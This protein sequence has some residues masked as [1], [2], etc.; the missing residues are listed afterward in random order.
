MLAPA[1]LVLAL[2]VLPQRP[3]E[4]TS[5]EI[6][7]LVVRD[8]TRH[9]VVERASNDATRV[10]LTW[11]DGRTA[12]ARVGPYALVGPAASTPAF[13]AARLAPLG[14][15]PVT[16]LS[17]RLGIVRV[18]S[19]TPGEDG[20]SIAARLAAMPDLDVL[21]D[22]AFARRRAAIDIP[23]DDPR[24]GGQWYLD[25][26]DIHAAWAIETGDP[27]V[28]V[29][30]VDD[31]CDL[32]HP[33]LAA[34]IEPGYDLVDGDDDPSFAPDLPGNEHGTA[35]AGLVAAIGDNGVGI[36]G[37][38][39]ECH[40]RCVRLLPGG[41]GGEVPIG[42]DIA[43]YDRQLEWDVAVSSNSWGF[44]ERFPVPVL[45]GR[46]ITTLATQGRGGL[47]AIVLFAI[48]NDAREV[49]DDELYGLEGVV[50][51]G[52]I[53]AFDEAAQ[54]S[55]RGRAL[56]LVAPAG[57][58]TTDI[59]GRD[60]ADPGDYT[61]LFGGTSS[62]CPVAAGVA[63]LLVAA[64]PDMRA[65]AIVG[66]LIASARPAPFAEPDEHGHDLLYGYGIIAPAAALALVVPPVVEPEPIAEEVAPEPG[67]EPIA[68]ASPEP[69][70]D[71]AEVVEPSPPR[72]DDGCAGGGA[73]TLLFTLAFG[74][75]ASRSRRRAT[76]AR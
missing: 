18:R 48:G 65:E 23:P 35:C 54:F 14:L 52:A 70:E 49:Q 55:N 12:V 66:A 43:A 21:P 76:R 17:E 72:R 27:S 25:T 32:A 28:V 50:T 26:I 4:L 56:D 58:L 30:V 46:A 47:G 45:L 15:E 11:P 22:F 29:G 74:V 16:V 19:R 36:A 42:N 69:A 5:T 40:L 71:P 60:G 61:S 2:L 59:S 33:D 44:T 13:D 51:I 34:H 64:A 38:C 62:A 39:P 20:L 6:A 57:T 53:N 41:I 75:S 7:A 3:P 73:P 68:E 24:H 31:G 9:I 63:A 8:G 67:P 37:T 10:H 1:C